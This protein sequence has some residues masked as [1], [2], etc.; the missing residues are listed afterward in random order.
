MFLSLLSK[1]QKK[2]FV[3]AAYNIAGSDGDFSESERMVIQS[4]SAEMGIEI[5]LEDVDTDMNRVI[6][7]INNLC[8]IREKKIIIFEMIGLAKADYNYDEGERKI[9]RNALK[10][11]GLDADFGDYCEK[12]LTEYLSLQE[13]L[14]SKIL[15]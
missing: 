10:I 1:D 14:N 8:G 5:E 6:S 15:S 13:E 12:K 2:L 4:Y 7:E 3:S 9:I 11:F